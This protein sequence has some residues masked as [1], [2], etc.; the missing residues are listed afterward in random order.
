MSASAIP[1]KEG[2]NAV[3]EAL[4]RTGMDRILAEFVEA[5]ERAARAGFDMIELHG[6]HGY[7][8]ASFLS[9]LTNRRTDEYGGSAENQARYPLEIFKAMRA[10]WPEDRPMSVR[11]SAWDWAAGGM[12]WDDLKV[13]AQAFREAGA[14]LID[15][16]TGQTVPHQKP[17]YGR[18]YQVPFS[19]FIR[20]ELDAPTMTVGAIT[21]PEQ[22]NMIL[23]A[24]RADLVALAR[25]HL[26][27]PAFTRAAAAHYGVTDPHWP[28]Q[29]STGVGQMLR[30]AEK[31]NE[32]ARETALKLRPARRHYVKAK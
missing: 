11:L 25:P 2:V 12:T 13:I 10:A 32:K 24:G 15:V 14:D 21:Q 28:I 30:E 9:P 16:S 5:T 8:I 20:N 1:F 7:L 18:M 19:E 3:P 17:V 4:D 6:A 31:Q 29:Y 23:G 22:I 26:N 27:D